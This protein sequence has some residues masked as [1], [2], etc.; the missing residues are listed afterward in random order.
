MWWKTQRG[1]GSYSG[2]P[3][4]VSHGHEGFLPAWL[5][6][7]FPWL[8]SGHDKIATRRNG[9]KESV[10][11]VETP[12]RCVKWVVNLKWKA[13]GNSQLTGKGGMK[14]LVFKRKQKHKQIQPV[15]LESCSSRRV[16]RNVQKEEILNRISNI[17]KEDLIFLGSH[18]V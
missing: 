11:G 3:W 13:V 15:V 17:T 1:M 16:R 6:K 4:A 12:R 2:F 18:F 7:W 9:K 5:A 8:M 14:G 10:S